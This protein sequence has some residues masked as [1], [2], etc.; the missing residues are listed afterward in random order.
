MTYVQPSREAPVTPDTFW[1]KVDVRGPDDCWEWQGSRS[2][3]E[4]GR[5]Y[6]RAWA[7]KGRTQLAHR[8][9]WEMANGDI[10]PG[11]QICHHCDNPPCVNPAH[12]FLGTNRD[13]VLDGL[14]K[15]RIAPPP[16][17]PRR[18]VCPKGHAMTPENTYVRPGGSRGYDYRECRTCKR[19]RRAAHQDAPRDR[20]EAMR[21]YRLR[22]RAGGAS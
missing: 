7:G 15:G 4:P 2:T 22:L 20:R 16:L 9:S 8:L 3:S 10:P 21:Q 19:E 5:D 11:M 12:L 13:N 17:T 6:G 18:E 1:S 14:A